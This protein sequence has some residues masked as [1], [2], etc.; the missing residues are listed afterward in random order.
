MQAWVEAGMAALQASGAVIR[1]HFRAGLLADDKADESP[2]T[3]ADR[4]AEEIL[5][6][7]LQASC[8]DCGIIGEEFPPYRADAKYVWV[9]DPI[10]GTRAFITGRPSFCT[11]LGLLDDGVP[12]LGFID[13]PITN[14]R[15][16]GGRGVGGWFHGQYGRF[17][18]RQHVSLAQAEL[19]STAPEMFSVPEM[20]R[21]MR[22]Q[23]VAK[24]VYWGGDAYG[25]GLLA[26][27]Q[28]DVVAECGLKP[29]D[30]AA[31]VPVVE[32]AGGV[33]SDWQGRPLKLGMSGGDVLASANA[34]LHRA[35]LA[36]LA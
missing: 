21:F 25:Y 26:L 16:C 11:L 34:A 12:V 28:V 33:V 7:S 15:W 18:T 17:G 24:R 13:Q 9:I 2:V 32:A 10:D 20:A 4:G 27:G 8:P 14:E 19:S 23:A 29:W 36:A 1:P 22:L 5:R 31:L 6:A 3:I 30:W 35:A